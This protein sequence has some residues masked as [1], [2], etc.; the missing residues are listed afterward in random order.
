MNSTKYIGMDVHQATISVAVRDSAG[1]LVMESVIETK[2]ATI[3]EF[4]GGLRGSLWVTFEE[5]TSAAWLYDLLKPHVTKVV[6]CNPRKNALLRSGNKNDRVDARKLA[7]L[8][9]TG[10]LSPVYHGESGVRTLREL[11]RSYLT[12]TKDLT[13]VMRRLKALY[14]SWAIPCSGQTVYASRHR[15]AWLEKLTEAGVRRRAERLFQQLDDL[16]PLRRQARRE[17]LVESRKHPAHTWLRQIPC[18]GP[19]RTALLIALIQTPHRFRTKRQL[20]AYGG[21]ALD[22]RISGEY[23]FAGGQLQRSKKL[24]TLRGLNANHN[25][26]LKNV[27]KST[28]TMASN[29]GGTLPRFLQCSGG[30]R[31]EALDGSPHT[32]A[33]DCGYHFGAVEERRTFRRGT[34]DAAS[35]LSVWSRALN[36]RPGSF[37]AVA[38]S[39]SAGARVRGRV[40]KRKLG[41][42]RAFG[43]ESQKSI[44]CPLGQPTRRDSNRPS[45]NEC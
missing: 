11:A 37:L 16:Q 25:H 41:S 24:L 17:L 45:S 32:G 12:I 15:T 14:R 21:L 13:R 2:A 20:W 42:P 1:K 33:Q 30:Q 19:I 23:R 9:R 4:L 18:V 10:L 28:A 36:L 8:L 27:F 31:D 40:S 22:T 7:E 35:S 38:L 29:C 26:E 34:T 44:L 5:G 43:T 39:G 6:V 3:L